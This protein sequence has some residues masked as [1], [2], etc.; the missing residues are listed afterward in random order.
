MEGNKMKRAVFSFAVL[1]P[2]VLLACGIAQ[3]LMV[4]VPVP[5]LANQAQCIALGEVTASHSAWN[6][7]GNYIY[8]YSTVALE[9]ALKGEFA[10]A[11]FTVR[12]PG[13]CVGNITQWVEDQPRIDVGQKVLLLLNKTE[14]GYYELTEGVQSKFTIAEGLV[15]ERGVSLDAFFAHLN[16][17]ELGEPQASPQDVCVLPFMGVQW[18]SYWIPVPM[19]A[20]SAG[21]PDCEGEFSALQRGGLVW[22]QVTNC[23][24]A[25]N[26]GGYTTLQAGSFDGKNVTSWGTLSYN[27]LAQ[28]TVWYS[29]PNILEN[30]TKF[31]E[32]HT[33]SAN[34]DPSCPSGRYDVQSIA[35]HEYGHDLGIADAYNAD[36]RSATM[37]GYGYSGDVSARTLEDPDRTAARTLYPQ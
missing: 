33:W 17:A 12:T 25:F 3:A 36:C 34:R 31:N 32:T 22:N 18:P 2:M 29:G 28:T 8:T 11:T 9:Q 5:E 21:T 4:Q 24:F 37:Y 19:W 1:G 10:V 30:D 15:E 6:A 13:G 14:D 35:A 16:G 23:Y 7:K 27:I 20:N 26:L